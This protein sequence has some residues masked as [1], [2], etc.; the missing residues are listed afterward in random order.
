MNVDALS[1]NLVNL[2]KED[3]DFGCDVM[4]FEDKLLSMNEKF[5]ND[6]IINLFILQLMDKET[7]EIRE[8][9]VEVE[10]EK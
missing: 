10:I 3:D 4:E 9:Q 6:I 2:W 5:P 7:I 8:H 1:R